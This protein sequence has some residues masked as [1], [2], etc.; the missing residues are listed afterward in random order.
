MQAATL[1]DYWGAIEAL[2]TWQ[3]FILVVGGSLLLA[4]AI[5]VGGNLLVPRLTTSIPGDVDDVILGGL[6]PAMYV[7]VV[8]AGAGLG[9]LLF[10]L[11]PATLE[12]IRNAMLSIVTVVWAVTLVRIGRGV[13]R[14]VTDSRYLD[15]QVVPIFQNVWSVVVVG[16]SIVLLLALWEIDVTPLLASAGILGIV[17][18]LA[19]RDTIANF[20]GSLA[21]YVDGTYRVGDYVVLESGERGR[22]EDISV[23]S[24][25]IRTR[26]DILVTVPNALLNNGTVVNESTPK[27]KRRIRVPIGVAY[28]SD[29][30]EVEALLL[31][32][33]EGQEQVLDRP[34]PRVRFREFGDSALQFELLCWV[35]NPAVRA[36]VA[37]HINSAVYHAFQDAGVEIPF[38]QRDVRLSVTDTDRVGG[39]GTIA[40]ADAVDGTETAE[41]RDDEPAID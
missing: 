33:A 7:T 12:A 35:P 32:A 23:R 27:R 8:L 10:D 13:S 14:R 38:P 18:G 26:D 31:E 1:A 11:E 29:I 2:P 24:T 34:S 4:A 6:H 3:G 37:H 22:V 9:L 25:V 17:I 21:L 28:G 36:R 19:A 39:D 20:F 30:D 15:R 5:N 16:V 40:T 41:V